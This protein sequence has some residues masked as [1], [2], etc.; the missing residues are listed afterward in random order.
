MWI[1]NPDNTA[2]HEAR[3]KRKQTEKT[4]KVPGGVIPSR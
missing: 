3:E 1:S 2:W 4:A